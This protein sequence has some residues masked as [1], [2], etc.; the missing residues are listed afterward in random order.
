VTDA[1]EAYV[2]YGSNGNNQVT[3]G[4]TGKTATYTDADGDLVTIRVN[5][6]TLSESDFQLGGANFLGGATLQKIDFSSHGDLEGAS[7]RISAQPQVVNGTLHGDG[8]ANVGAFVADQ[9]NLGKVGIAG[10]LGRIVASSVKSLAVNSIG[11]Q[12]LSTQ[13]GLDSSLTSIVGTVAKLSVRTNIEGVTIASAQFG[14]AR[15]GGDLQDSLLILSGGTAAAGKP[16][17]AI[18]SL[19]IG[20]DLDHTQIWVVRARSEVSQM[21]PSGRCRSGVI[22]WRAASPLESRRIPTASSA[23]WT[24]NYTAA[25]TRGLSRVSRVS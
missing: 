24:I 12:G 20:G 21:W 11:T 10:D 5:K 22:G 18:K 4:S 7:V 6:G 15:V 13:A 14:K 16:A 3:I 2:L 17:V 8:L 9:I 19:A 1:G 25:A 23:A